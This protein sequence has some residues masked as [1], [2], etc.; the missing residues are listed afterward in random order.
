[1]ACVKNRIKA[2]GQQFGIKR[3]CVD[4]FW[5]TEAMATRPDEGSASPLCQITDTT[6]LFA[7]IWRFWH[8][9][10]TRVIGT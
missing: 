7:P 5:G 9:F 8:S 10:A 2:L 6:S 3:L 4:N 1:M